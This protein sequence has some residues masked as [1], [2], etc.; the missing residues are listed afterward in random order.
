MTYYITHIKD[1]L[2]NYYLGIDIPVNIAKPFLNELEEILGDD[3][4]KYTELQKNRDGDK[5]HITVINCMD[6]NRL[7][8]EMG[9]DK[10]AHSLDLIFK[11]PIDD[12]KMLGVGK[13]QKNENTA[14][15]IVCNSEKLTA[16]RNRYELRSQDFH[17]TIGF[18]YSD[19]FGV[20]KNEVMEK[21]NNF[22]KLLS[23]EYYKNENWNFVKDIKNFD[24]DR[25]SEIIPVE[26][27]KNLVKIKCDGYFM[28]IIYL[29][30]SFWIATKYSANKELPNLSEN[31]IAKTFKKY[32]K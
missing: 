15:F 9:S 20:R 30:N 18:L 19:V 25:N 17:T 1:F 11:Y 29:E 31:E 23:N 13:A 28:D 2:G 22:L 5:Y 26:I 10:F 21:D 4:S 12:I 24:L 32:L 7:S 3:Y 27:K 8:K 6:Y 14:Y 16:V